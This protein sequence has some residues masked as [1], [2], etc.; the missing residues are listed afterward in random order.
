MRGERQESRVVDRLAA[1]EAADHDFHIVVQTGRSRAAQVLEG[2]DVFADRGFEV[3][4]FHEPQIL[5]AGIC[6]HVAEQLHPAPPLDR[7]VEGVRRIIHLSLQS[8][9]RLEADRRQ[10]RRIGA[11]D[12]QPVAD[13]RVAARESLGSQFL[14]DPRRRDVGISRNQ[15]LDRRRPSVQ[16]ARASETRGRIGARAAGFV[17]R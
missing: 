6:Q 16:L 13:D 3:L 9:P 15:A 17:R 2:S 4:M 5:P 1:V 14:V 12:T 11:N 10:P 7:E 8:G